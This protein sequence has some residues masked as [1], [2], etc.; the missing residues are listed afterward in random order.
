MGRCGSEEDWRNIDLIG[1]CEYFV[2][3]SFALYVDYLYDS[4][5]E[6]SFLGDREIIK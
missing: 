6:V 5:A 2:E 4:R 1:L 3:S